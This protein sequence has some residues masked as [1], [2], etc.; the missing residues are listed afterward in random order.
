MTLPV[1]LAAL[2]AGDLIIIPGADEGPRHVP[3]Q[4]LRR[5]RPDVRRS[6]PGKS[7]GQLNSLIAFRK[8]GNKK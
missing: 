3:A 5:G 7:R 8:A 1:F 2:Q 4:A 6:K